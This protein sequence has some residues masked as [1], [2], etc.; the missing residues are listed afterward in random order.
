MPVALPGRQPNPVSVTLRVQ[1]TLLSVTRAT[2]RSER[3]A[4]CGAWRHQLALIIP[5]AYSA[6][7]RG[8]SSACGS[9]Q[10]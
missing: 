3:P 6:Y 2:V 5:C 7:L 4:P 9:A 1:R 10:G 8:A